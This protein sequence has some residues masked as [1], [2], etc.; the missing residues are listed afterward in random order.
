MKRTWTSLALIVC[1]ACAALLIAQ[2]KEDRTLLS[3][4]QMTAIINEVS[5]E[6]AMHHV[7]ELVPYQFVRPPAEYQG[8]FR[9][10]EVMARLA[11]EYG[12]S[13]VVIEDYPTGQTW[14]PVAGEL[15]TTAPKSIKLY[16]IH[17]IPEALA[18]TNANADLSGDLVSIG[19]GTAQELEGK[20]LKGKFALALA[21]SGLGA[22]YSRA[23]AAGAIGVIGIS[24]I[25]AGDR[26]TDFPTEIVSTT[27]SAQPNTAAWAVSPK[28]ARELETLLN[29]GQKVTIRS[30][31]KSEQV[32]NKQELVHAEIPGDGSTTQQVAMGG[33]LF[34]G[35]IKQGA[36]DDNSGCAL[37]LEIGRAYLKLIQEGKLPRPKRTINFQ[38]VQEISGTNAWFNAHP[39]KQ[40]ALIG[41]LNFDMEG[42]R[43]TPSRAYWILHRTPDTFPSYINDIAQSMMEYIAEVSRERV[44]YRSAG[45]GA[46]Q[47]VESPNGSTDAFYIKIDKHYGSSDHVTYMQHGIPAVI[48]NTWPDMWYHSSQDTPDKQD[49][50][51]YK[52]AAAVGLGALAALASG[53][54]EMAARVLSENLGRGLGRMGESHTK[55]LGYMA[56]ATDAASLTDAYKEARVAIV[57]QAE[58]EKG[59]VNSAGVLWTNADAGKKKTAGFAPLIDQRAAALLNETKAAF[60]LQAAQRGVPVAEP[61]QTAEE[62]EAA[63][64]V[65]E[66][67][68]PAG[69]GGFGGGGGRGGRGNAGPSVPQEMNAEFNILL[70]QHKTVL[71][72]RDFLSGEFTPL[73]LADLMAVLRAREAAG[74]IKLVP[75]AKK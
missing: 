68:A 61:V 71:E 74:A 44:R 29:R 9:E 49:P 53:S 1:L 52:R 42:L 70:G 12:F 41:D 14:Q 37:T 60:Q 4:E 31:T 40:K 62:R 13:N 67:T 26:A 27:V 25:G 20:D 21:P 56:D 15:W 24:A 30:I 69:R 47:P 43:L 72:I 64:L 57:H 63:N 11:K 65:V 8:H 75:K 48:F 17:D 73:P 50:T 34:E 28:V 2:E 18:S 36:N 51:Q 54:D 66:S 58:V 35:Y 3:H 23:V 38:W 19:Q 55:G 59:V 32:P 10:S 45:Y 39:E 5:G 7:L 46:S 33:H 6:R 16:D 22:T